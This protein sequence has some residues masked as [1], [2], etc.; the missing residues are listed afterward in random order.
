[1]L[2]NQIIEDAFDSLTQNFKAAL[3]ISLIPFGIAVAAALAVNGRSIFLM[4]DPQGYQHIGGGD[5]ALFFLGILFIVIAG[6]YTAVRWHLFSLNIQGEAGLKRIFAYLFVA[7]VISLI[8]V[9]PA[10]LVGAVGGLL[11]YAIGMP[12]TSSF[13]AQLGLNALGTGVAAY[14]FLRFSTWL[15]SVALNRQS[16]Q[17]WKRTSP[18]HSV[19]L[20]TAVIYTVAT[21]LWSLIGLA[22]LPIP[23]AIVVDVVLSW[24]AFMMSIAVL[25]EIYR[26]TLPTDPA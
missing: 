24:L 23:V 15:V 12:P 26:M 4:F 21:F 18:L 14:V 3:R 7:F 22:G 5:V 9:L 8:S 11:F 20:H 25:T 1:M 16:S 6:Y 17:N 10:F 2:T 19:I 13:L